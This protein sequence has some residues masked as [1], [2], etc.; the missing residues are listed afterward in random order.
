MMWRKGHFL[1]K[2]RTTRYPNLK[3]KGPK[4]KNMDLYLILYTKIN[5]VDHRPKCKT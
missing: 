5:S 3:K 1:A 2:A 4:T